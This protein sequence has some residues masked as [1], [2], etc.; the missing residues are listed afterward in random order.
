MTG[1]AADPTLHQDGGHRVGE[2][3]DEVSFLG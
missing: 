1:V 3:S 2:A